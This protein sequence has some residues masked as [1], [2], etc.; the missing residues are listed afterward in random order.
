M[1][2]GSALASN[3]PITSTHFVKQIT[4]DLLANHSV[5]HT[6]ISPE[7]DFHYQR[8]IRTS[9]LRCGTTEHMVGVAMKNLSISSWKLRV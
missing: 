8:Q 1:L 6:V 5:V 4:V 9:I 3:S 7:H 2:E